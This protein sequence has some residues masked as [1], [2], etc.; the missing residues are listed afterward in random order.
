MS[1][2]TFDIFCRVI[3]NYG[4]IGVCWRLARQLAAMAR[5]GAVRLWVDNLHSFARIQPGV[6]TGAPIQHAAGVEIRHWHSS[7]DLPPPHDVVIEAFACDPPAEFIHAMAQRGSDWVNLEYL[8]AEDWVRGCHALPSLQP[9]G[10]RKAFFF[11]G[12]VPGTGGLPREPGLL[13]E[14]DRWLTRPSERAA[15]LNALGLASTDVEA[16]LEGRA[17]QVMLFCYPDAPA[18]ALLKALAS[19]AVP[20]IVLVPT[21]VCPGL[22]RGTHGA[23][24]VRDIPFI[25]QRGFDRL[26]WSSDLNCVRGEDSLVRGLWA[27]RPLL[28]HIYRQQD[29]AHLLKLDAWLACSPLNDAVKQAMRAWNT[30][31]ETSLY[32][33][34]APLLAPA[35][36]AQWSSA[37]AGWCT[38]LAGRTDLATTLVDF[39]STQRQ[40]T[41]R[42][43]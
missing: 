17:R 25:D 13:Q 9:S 10:I 7:A 28:W 33:A 16:L 35:P 27:G 24:R 39:V 42:S 4:D 18:R 20:S 30:S 37:M 29:E 41:V 1:A 15:L 38:T 2:L 21:G 23:V 31:D 3:D 5:V 26:L 8:S 34:L 40:A 36:L 22:P 19:R 6:D 14:R 32:A 43:P 11:P 12:F